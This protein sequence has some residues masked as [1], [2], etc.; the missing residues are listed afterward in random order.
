MSIR[1]LPNAISLLRLVLVAPLLFSIYQRD[2]T[3]VLQLVVVMAALD[4]LDGILARKLQAVTQLGAVLDPLAD[5]LA[6]SLGFVMMAVIGLIPLW[7]AAVVFLRDFIIA[8]GSLLYYI[9]I[10]PFKVQ[11]VL[12]GKLNT[13]FLSVYC[14]FLMVREADYLV[15]DEMFYSALQY[16]CTLVIVASL[17]HYL[18]MGVRER[19]KTNVQNHF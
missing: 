8:V 7:F 6:I 12:L 18:Y 16:L 14:A 13:L 17:T 5:K 15:L 11:P 4:I 3:L 2:F 1:W 10:G 9:V 19:L